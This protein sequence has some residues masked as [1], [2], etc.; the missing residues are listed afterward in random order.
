MHSTAASS[1]RNRW[2]S[3]AVWIVALALVTA[4]MTGMRN[5]LGAAHIVPVYLLLVLGASARGGRALGFTLAVLAFA[6]F[7]FFFVPPF[8]TFAVANPLDWWVLGAFFVTSA[9]ATQ[10]L[11]AAQEQAAEARRRAADIDRLASL[12][13][14]TLN[15]G[16]A[17]DAL[18]AI[19]DVIRLAVSAARC[20]VH[21]MDGGQL[22]LAA[23]SSATPTPARDVAPERP[24]GYPDDERLVAWVA[25]HDRPAVVR[26]DGSLRFA[27]A[28]AAQRIPW[29]GTDARALLLPLHVHDRSVGVLMLQHQHAMSLDEGAHRL[30][31]TLAYY[32]A[33][34]AE[35]VR[36][37]RA[38]DNADALR[39]ADRL[40]DALLMSVSHDLRT[41]LTTIKALAHAISADGDDRA[42][43]IEEEADRLNRLVADL[44]DLSRL[45]SGALSVSAELNAAEDLLG[46][47]L[48]RVS[49]AAGKR[50]IEV[51]L[52]TSEPLLL[53]RFDFTHSLRVLVNL[54]ENALKYSPADTPIEIGAH[55]AG[56]AREYLEFT[57]ADRGGGIPDGEQARIFEPFYRPAGSVPDAG[58]AGLGLSIARRLAEAQGGALY[59]AP[60]PG[61]GSCFALRVPAADLSELAEL[62]RNAPTSSSPVFV[63]S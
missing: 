1:A 63:K 46:V 55:R 52:D 61:G 33:L 35:R 28:D 17:E 57:V 41:P 47:A 5:R 54:V 31:E 34:G 42:L 2:V 24:S 12:G 6:C 43:T 48:E 25:E 7:N 58:S 20:E 16:R 13:A 44:L 18:T 32:A 59:Y 8:Y 62:S 36:L 49:G 27:D 14:E 19:A 39:E 51:S 45:A 15:A 21:L 30:L 3:W 60:R 50:A 23:S 26:T 40:K 10:L 56:D 53:G 9:V 37:A 22:A 38:A 29:L 4:L 11:A